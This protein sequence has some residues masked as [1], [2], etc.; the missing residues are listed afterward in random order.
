MS[1]P[2]NAT[3][4]EDGERYYEWNGVKYPSVT[5]ILHATMV[6]PGLNL[7]YAGQALE[8]QERGEEDP[9]FAAVRYRDYAADRGSRVHAICEALILGQPTNY[10]DEEAPYIKAFLQWQADYRPVYESAEITVYSRLYRYAG[11]IDIISD[12]GVIDLKTSKSLYPDQ[13]YQVAAYARADTLRLPDDTAQD[14]TPSDRAAVLHL[15]PNGTYVFKYVGNVPHAF[16]VF[17]KALALYDATRSVK[18]LLVKA[19]P[20]ADPGF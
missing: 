16:D 19:Q 2:A 3:T 15:R 10:S 20:P 7:W 1:E 14:F 18:G 12:L 11:T 4:H 8:A 17:E 5:T 9:K 6:K 13:A